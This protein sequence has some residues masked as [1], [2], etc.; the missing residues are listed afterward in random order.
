MG[1]PAAAPKMSLIGN[2]DPAWPAAA[3]AIGG[4]AADNNIRLSSRSITGMVR[5]LGADERRFVGADF[6]RIPFRELHV[7]CRR[8]GG[9]PSRRVLRWRR[10]PGPLHPE[11]A[12]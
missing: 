3:I 6:M 11:R 9:R 7:L 12:V 2:L 8:S 10:S 4:A 1:K 5:Q